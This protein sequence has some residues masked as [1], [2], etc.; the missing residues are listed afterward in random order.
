VG[1]KPAELRPELGRK[2]EPFLRRVARSAQPLVDVP[3]HALLGEERREWLV[4]VYPVNGEGP[5][6]TAYVLLDITDYRYWHRLLDRPAPARGRH[7][8]SNRVRLTRREREVLEWIGHGKTS[9]D[10]A[11]GLGMS[12]LTVGNHRKQICRKLGLHT[13]AELA[14][15][16]AKQRVLGE[17]DAGLDFVAASERF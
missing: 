15:Y 14:A 16:A 12:V 17:S 10:I 5:A 3:I 9:K 7:K 13:T 11:A 2:I 1:K 8:G 4:S 6:R